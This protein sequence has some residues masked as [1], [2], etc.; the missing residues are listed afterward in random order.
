M[1][2]IVWER[3]VGSVDEK[4]IAK[5]EEK[6]S[7][8][9]PQEYKECVMKYNGGH[10]VPN[11]FYFTDEGE[12]CFD[13]LLSFTSDPNIEDVYDI[14]SDYVPEGI[15]PFATDPFGNDICF[16]YR[17]NKQRPNIVFRNQ[18]EIGDEAIEFI[19]ETFTEF[20][21]NLHDENQIQ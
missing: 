7:I 3:V 18:D 10:P 13:H 6:F 4:T 11:V 9:F 12:G 14:I 1:I 8:R 15:I 2:K 16:D 17:K 5:V 19:C 21:E 20:L